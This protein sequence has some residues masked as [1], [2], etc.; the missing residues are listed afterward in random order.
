[1]VLD[2]AKVERISAVVRCNAEALDGASII[3]AARADPSIEIRPIVLGRSCI[4]I[5]SQV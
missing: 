2:Y 1:M 3:E 5:A 4:P